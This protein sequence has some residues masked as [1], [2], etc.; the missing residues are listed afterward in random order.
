MTISIEPRKQVKDWKKILD[1]VNKVN[2]LTDRVK[3][4]KE[5]LLAAPR[6]ISAVRSR[7]ATESWKETEGYPLT[8]RRAKS[9]Q[10][11]MEGNPVA[12]WDDELIVGSQSEF[13]R[14]AGPPTDFAPNITFKIAGEVKPT[15]GSKVVFALLSDK[16]RDSL[17]EDAE[18]WKVRSPVDA[19]LKLIFEAVGENDSTY[20]DIAASGAIAFWGERIK[21][22]MNI[23]YG[24]AIAL[25]FNGII[26]EAEE[27][28]EKAKNLNSDG[29]Y[30]KIEFLK[31][32]IICCEAVITFAKK[33]AALAREMAGK[34]K[35]PKRKAELREIAKTCEWVPAN[36]ARTF[37]EALQ[38][39]WL[40]HLAANLEGADYAETPGRLDQYLYP[41]YEKDI[42]EGRITCQDAAELMGC[43][44]VKLNEMECVR[45]EFIQKYSQSSQNQHITISGVNEDGLD[46][47]NELSFIILEVARKLRLPQSSIYIR[48]H[49]DI[50]EEFMVKAAETNRDHGAGIPAFL[51][52]NGSIFKFL[53]Q[54]I[55]LKEARNWCAI[56]C[57]A[58]ILSHCTGSPY[59][60]TILFN[61]SKIFE[62]TLNNGFDPRTKKQVG[63]KTGDPRDFKSYEEL[64]S[65]FLE[66]YKYFT[67]KAI[68]FMRAI[69]SSIK[70]FSSFPYCSMLTDDCIKRGKGIYQGGPRHQAEISV[71]DSGLQ[72]VA[73]SLSA[74]KKL[75]FEEKKITMDELLGALAVDFKGKEELRQLLLSAPCYGN[76]N[77]YPDNIFNAVSWDTGKIL[78]DYHY[79]SGLPT[80]LFRGGATQ[81]FWCGQTV[82]ALP[83]GRKGYEPVADAVLSPSQGKDVKGPT[84]IMLSATKMNHLE[85]AMASLHNVKISPSVLQTKEGINKFLALIKTYFERG[86]WHLQFNL[87]GQEVLIEAQKHPEKYR[88]LVVRVAGY[89]AFFIDLS[90]EVQNDI[91]RRTEHRL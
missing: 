63:P 87:M 7:L 85:H 72:N 58:P 81:H 4:R 25:G 82:G 18:Y 90:P 33:Y 51:N 78:T 32:G 74:M 30:E 59:S 69:G 73:D 60:G 12:I 44:W 13:L 46:A 52:D 6:H 20:Q 8:L 34:E 22:N 57:V 36:P 54:G 39:F 88:D 67:E 62:L 26:K 10:K 38:S 28:C 55:P 89:S 47:T 61:K 83:D 49:K 65:A 77:D 2:V 50:S 53:N 66:Q 70:T 68:R 91:I 84:A 71:L 43:M 80:V 21:G 15:T 41:Y 29:D 79:Y 1:E 17:R 23:D 3:K 31:A 24:K 5:E 64:Y 76:D 11:I 48:W 9:F 19:G 14:G 27:E 37:R 45:G 56:G 40:T 86:G 35:N 16:D 75:V 42:E